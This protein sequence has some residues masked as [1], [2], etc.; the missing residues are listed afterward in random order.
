MNPYI[1]QIILFAGTFSIQRY[2][3]CHGQLLPVSQNQALFSLL[4]TMYGGDG[5]TTYGLP[6]L[7]GR[8]PIHRGQGPGIPYDFR[9]GSKG[10]SEKVT[11]V[12]SEMPSHN[13]LS[14][15]VSADGDSDDPVNRQL[16]VV[17]SPYVLYTTSGNPISF[18]AKAVGSSGGTQA[19]NNIQ[20]SIVMT[21][22]ISL[23]GV[24]PSRN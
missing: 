19:H 18:N 20:P 16:A 23:Y 5:R 14:R 21:Y 3:L 22:Q 9:Q 11:L 17:P 8:I 4:G 12:T 6:D 2:A 1:G 7:R 10:G 24:Y 13:H 15:A